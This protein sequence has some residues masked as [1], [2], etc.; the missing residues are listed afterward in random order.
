MQNLIKKMIDDK[1]K[2]YYKLRVIFRLSLCLLFV[3]CTRQKEETQYEY[4]ATDSVRSLI[5]DENTVETEEI[6]EYESPIIDTD[7]SLSPSNIQISNGESDNIYD[8]YQDRLD[9]YLDDPEDEIRF[10]PEV[11]DFQDD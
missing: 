10:D 7:E 6:Y 5:N 4:E 8:E 9:D 11:F 3:N 1:L 2:K